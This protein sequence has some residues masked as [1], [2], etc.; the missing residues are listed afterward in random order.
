M[1][2]ADV[3][4]SCGS[5]GYPLNLTSSNRI[6]SDIGSGYRKSIKKGSIS[7]NSIDL[8]RFTQ[9]MVMETHP[10]MLFVDVML[11]VHPVLHIKSL[12]LLVRFQNLESLSLSGCTNLTDAGLTHLQSYGSNLQFLHLDCCFGI[13]D[14]GLSLVATGCPSLTVISL[15]RCFGITDLGLEILA[16]A[17]S[18]L[19]DWCSQTLCYVEAE[20]C[21][22]K[23][24][25]INGIVSGGGIEYLDVSR[26]SWSASEDSF[27]AIGIG[28]ASSLKILNLRMCRFVGD[29]SIIAIAKG[30][31]LLEEWN[32]ALCHGVRIS[33]WEAIALNCHN[34]KIL[35]VNRCRNLCDRGL[36]ALRDGC[37]RLSILYMNGCSRLTSTAIEL[38]KC[39]RYNVHIK[40]DEIMCVGPNWAFR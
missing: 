35:H 28:S 12:L 14:S 32:L 20:S 26:L 1:S 36:H 15:Y 2:Q 23:P 3:S 16:S 11:P 21:K 38:F 18:S 7:F 25:G 17:C 29:N 13:T 33:G 39:Y 4:Y 37:K 27:A 34:L 22:F 31:P 10:H 8:S 40:E 19:K 9:A 30:C 5:C 24:E 6:T